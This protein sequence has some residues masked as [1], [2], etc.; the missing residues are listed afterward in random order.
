[1]MK[2]MLLVMVAS[3][4]AMSGVY[5]Q[6][7]EEAIRYSR[8]T[9]GGTARAL[10]VG[11]AF[12]AMGAD[13]SALSINPGGLGLYRSSALTFTPQIMNTGINSRFLENETEEKRYHFNINN[14]AL[15]ISHLKRDRHHEPVTEGWVATNFA[16]GFN[17][18]AH[19]HSKY[20]FSGFNDQSS[21]LDHY[22]TRLNGTHPSQIDYG[23]GFNP[24]L[25]YETYLLNPSAADSSQYE[26]V[27]RNGD[28]EQQGS[29]RSKGALDEMLFSFGANY[30]DK[31]YFG[32]S[33]GIP[34]VHYDSEFTYR[35]NDTRDSVPGFNS[36]ELNDFLS[37]NGAGVNFKFGL[38]YRLSEWIRLGGAIHSPTYLFLE[39]NYHSTM[40]SAF[41]TVGHSSESPSGNFEYNLTTPWKVVGSLGF[42]IKKHGFISIDYEWLDYTQAYYD[43]DA[44]FQLIASET[45]DALQQ[46]YGQASNL[47]IGGELSFEVLRFRAGYAFYGSPVGS[48]LFDFNADDALHQYSLGFGIRE[49]H[50]SLDFAFVHTESANDYE[51]YSLENNGDS[52][53]I[54]NELLRNQFTV[55]AGFRF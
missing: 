25:G 22:A 35:E 51:L 53:S 7:A 17:R 4:L 5:A 46:R 32:G 3:A 43:F 14:L 39:D 12:G 24:V 29:F 41:D 13:F 49:R 21:I 19:F 18:L 23:L 52:P 15:V 55:T 37:T 33:F 36:F 48:E 20:F 10:G 27:I 9:A 2:K 45:N 30:S 31:I 26:P 6:S 40:E 11:G 16:F 54:N 34:I 50:F 38:I 47:R 8:A 1:M 28:V 42:L 44:P